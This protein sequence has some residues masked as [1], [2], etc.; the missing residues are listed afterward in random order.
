MNKISYVLGGFVLGVAVVLSSGTVSA[1][2]NSLIGQKVTGEFTIIV[3]GKKLED[4]GAVISGRT[5]APV[6]ALSES[7]GADLKLDN[8]NKVISITTG[9][10]DETNSSPA[11]ADQSKEQLLKQKEKL[12]SDI[13]YLQEEKKKTEIKYENSRIPGTDQYEAESVWKNAIEILD[14]KIKKANEEL[15]KIKDDLKQFD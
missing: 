6:R 1:K 13:T 11:K 2:I 3:D 7:L 9:S 4:K 8:E 5:N 14:G 10:V 12:E 15:S